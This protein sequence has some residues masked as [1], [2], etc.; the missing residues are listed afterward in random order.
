MKLIGRQRLPLERVIRRL[1]LRQNQPSAPVRQP[2]QLPRK[3]TVGE[4]AAPLLPPQLQLQPDAPP[5]L[6]EPVQVAHRKLV[7]YQL[8]KQ[9]RQ[10]FARLVRKPELRLKR[11]LVQPKLPPS[12]V[13]RAV[14]LKRRRALRKLKAWRRIRRN[15]PF[16]TPADLKV[17]RRARRG[18]PNVR[19]VSVKHG[20]HQHQH[21]PKAYLVLPQRAKRRRLKRL[22]VK[23]VKVSV[24]VRLR[25]PVTPARKKKPATAK[26][27]LHLQR[28]P[29]HGLHLLRQTFLKDADGNVRLRPLPV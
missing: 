8:N 21:P 12:R 13:Q 10:K 15:V 26:P 20:K 9:L 27:P 4:N 16:P 1:P 2:V 11:R 29:I 19:Q 17:K 7:L 18:T 5:P 6:L 25:K 3:V 23:Q 22:R 14:L 28:L 24:S